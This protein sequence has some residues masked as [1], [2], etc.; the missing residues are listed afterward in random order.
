MDYL[1]FRIKKYVL[2]L[3]QICAISILNSTP[4]GSEND[5]LTVLI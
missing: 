5:K 2:S 3:I 1:M 4:A